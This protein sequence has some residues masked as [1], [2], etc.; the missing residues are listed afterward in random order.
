LK[1]VLITGSE[2][3]IGKSLCGQLSQHKE[4]Y[5]V[6]TLSRSA[7]QVRHIRADITVDNLVPEISDINPEIIVHLAGN[8]SVPF[9]IKYPLEDFNVNARGTLAVLAASEHTDCNNFVF[10][11]SGGAIYDS[12]AP[13]PFTEFSPINPI[14]PYGLSKYIAEGYVRILN[15]ARKSEWSSLALSNAYGSVKIQKQGVIYRFWDDISNGINPTIFGADVSRDFIHIDDVVDAIIKVIEKPVNSRLNISSNTS[16]KLVDLLAEMQC[17]MGSS[18]KPIIQDLPLGEVGTSQLSNKR[19]RELLN[20]AP[21][22]DLFSSLK[23]I[24]SV[25]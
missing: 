13:S 3:F 24:L 17:I 19:A 5:E 16:T 18:F 11:T 7:G 9:S 20:W 12:K 15:E 2:G 4:S 6:F 22:V 21:R 14:S 10:V 25:N 23:D 1:R 8:V